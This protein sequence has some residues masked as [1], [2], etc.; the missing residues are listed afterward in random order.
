MELLLLILAI[1]G[2]V[3]WLWRRLFSPRTDDYINRGNAHAERGEF[4]RAI[5]AFDQALRRDI[6]SAATYVKR[7][8]V[9]T[10][11]G[12]YDRAFRDFDQALRL[13]YDRAEIEAALARLPESFQPTGLSPDT[14]NRD[15][16]QAH[17]HIKRGEAYRRKG[18]A[19]R[20]IQAFDQALRLDPNLVDAYL[21]RGGAYGERGEL[22]PG[23][24]RLRSGSPACPEPSEPD[25][26][27]H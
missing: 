11:Q 26:S 6:Y 25:P 27:Q 8:I 15:P 21:G 10:E 1:I 24:P 7:G 5:Q 16:G 3:I 9:Y 4:D 2:L 19:D 18:E 23:H 22:G 12:R 20:A 14:R 13:G 17:Q